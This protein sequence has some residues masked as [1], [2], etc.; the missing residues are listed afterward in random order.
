MYDLKNYNEYI[1]QQCL[2]EYLRTCELSCSCERCLAD[3]KAMV[4]NR[5]PPKYYVTLRGEI[6]TEVESHSLPNKARLFAA[7]AQAAKQVSESPSHAQ[8]DFDQEEINQDRPE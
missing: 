1:V 5:L 6:I 2:T 8:K 7:I 3:I 4:L